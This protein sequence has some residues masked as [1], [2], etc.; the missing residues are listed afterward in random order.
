M[1]TILI[2]GG[3]EFIVSE[4]VR[5]FSASG[6]RVI[7]AGQ[8]P[9]PDAFQHIQWS[10]TD[11]ILPKEVFE[12]VDVLLHTAY[13]SARESDDAL[14]LNHEGSRHLFDMAANAG[15]KHLIFLSSLSAKSNAV[16]IY[17]QQKWAVEQ[18]AK[19]YGATI[20]R[21]GLVIGSGGLLAKTFHHIKMGKPIPVFGNGRQ[22]M[23][24]I[25]IGDLIMALDLIT[26]QQPGKI[27]NL[28]APDPITYRTFFALLSAAANKSCRFIPMPFSIAFFLLRTAK[29][30]GI[31]LPIHIDHLKGLQNWQVVDCSSDLNDLQLSLSSTRESIQLVVDQLND[32]T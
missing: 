13:I 17:D 1:R 14:R 18:L 27:Y 7:T 26:E 20:V 29:K 25:F 4:I 31:Y 23:Q 10:L 21:P 8:K 3:I 5:H 28:A 22:P 9:H 12:H 15:V 24:T 16:S 11:H 2:T 6:F 19:K 32:H 30:L